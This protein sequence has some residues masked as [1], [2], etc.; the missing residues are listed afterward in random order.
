M[1]FFQENEAVYEFGKDVNKIVNIFTPYDCNKRCIF[2]TTKSW[3]KRRSRDYMKLWERN[4]QRILNN[5]PNIIVLTGGEVFSNLD[6]LDNTLLRI[7]NS[8]V[9]CVYV[10]TSF[11]GSKADIESYLTIIER[12][13]GIIRGV[14]ISRH[15]K[16]DTIPFLETLLDITNVRINIIIN[17]KTDINDYLANWKSHPRAELSFREDYKKITKQKLFKGDAKVLMQLTKCKELKLFSTNYC[18]F[19]C[20]YTFKRNNGQSVR[21]HRGTML[22]SMMI[23]S[24]REHMEIILAPNGKIYTDWDKSSDGID[25][26]LK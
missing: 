11:I 5:K 25:E 15:G 12:Y 4:F 13:R 17:D 26:L 16:N 22:T 8:G 6:W 20:N 19:C 18:H 2:C 14:N 3:Y 9:K 21:Y 7:R 10:N 24:H 1:H 23:G